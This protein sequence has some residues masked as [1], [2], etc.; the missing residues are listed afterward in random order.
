MQCMEIPAEFCS[1][2]QLRLK[3]ARNMDI[4]LLFTTNTAISM[5]HKKVYVCVCVCVLLYLTNFHPSL[6]LSKN[7]SSDTI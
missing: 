5:L 3:N 2:K 7:G 6:I 4:C 1:G